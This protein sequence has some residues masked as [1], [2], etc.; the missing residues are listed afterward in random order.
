MTT[1]DSDLDRIGDRLQVAWRS[2]A[3]RARR[4]R[5][6]LLG[7]GTALLAA[8]SV[9]FAADVFP[10][11][12]TGSSARP[13]RAALMQMRAAFQPVAAPLEPWQ[14]TLK[15]DFGKAVVVARITSRETGPLAIIVMP[16]VGHRVCFDAARPD[17]SSFLAG[18]DLPLPNPGPGADR[19]L[20]ITAGILD[21]FTGSDGVTHA[22]IMISIRNAPPH[23]VRI[24]VR[25]RD[26]RKLPAVVSHGWLV[27]VNQ[28][29]GAA[30]LVRVYD[31]SGKRLLSYDG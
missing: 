23:A 4:R 16:G 11:S 12:V 15:L 25:A 26:A 3:G 7:A 19:S 20:G 13:E 9:A 1:I 14:K 17:G 28:R 21:R 18:C 30:V 6:A 27:F 5:R 22:P 2:D 31:A 8:A 10:A 29:P 24:D